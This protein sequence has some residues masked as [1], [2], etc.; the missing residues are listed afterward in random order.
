MRR[1][2]TERVRSDVLAVHRCDRLPAALRDA[3][4]DEASVVRLR[5]AICLYPEVATYRGHG[6]I[7]KA[8]TFACRRPARA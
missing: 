4:A 2:A 7:T 6:D 3:T 8:E 5:D 1:T